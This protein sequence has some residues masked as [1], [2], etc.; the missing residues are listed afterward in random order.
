MQEQIDQ[1][2]WERRAAASV[3][4]M[5]GLLALGLASTGVHAVVAYATAQRSR[6]IGIRMALG[7]GRGVV[8]RQVA[9]QSLRLALVGIAAGIPIALWAKTV[10]SAFL[11]QTDGVGAATLG[12]VAALFAA[13]ALAA[14]AMP[15][16]KAASTDP[17]TVLRHE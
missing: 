3:L 7:A 4:T 15:A 10:A 9:G 1:S 6:E 13:I 17:A 5:F 8:Q 2:L 11:Y 16:R 12:G 14:S